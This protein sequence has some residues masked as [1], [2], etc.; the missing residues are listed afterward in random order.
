MRARHIILAVAA[1]IAA[2]NLCSITSFAAEPVTVDNFGRAESDLYFGNVV[3]DD[4]FGKFSHRREPA[5]IDNQTV[6]RLNRDTLYSAAVFDLDAGPV[7][8]T[9]PDAGR[10][11]M[12]LMAINEDHYVASVAYGGA[13]TFTRDK[14]G[15]RYLIVAIRT[16]V[17]PTDPKDVEQV[18]A[19]Q[20]AIKVIGRTG[21]I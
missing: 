1:G 21:Q 9:L 7:T 10:R 4:G 15:T 13:S 18:H 3:R 16:F 14:V 12:S 20:D 19:L 8:V 11:F 6:I 2:T 17:D 5:A